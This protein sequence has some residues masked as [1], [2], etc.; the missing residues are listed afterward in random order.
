LRHKAYSS[1]ADLQSNATPFR[2][3]IFNSVQDAAAG[4]PD[5]Y[6]TGKI[7][8]TAKF[9]KYIPSTGGGSGSISNKITISSTVPS[10]EIPAGT[11]VELKASVHG[12]KIYYTIDGTDPQIDE[13]GNLVGSTK[14]YSGEITITDDTTLKGIAVAASGKVK[15]EIG[16]WDYTVKGI[17]ISINPPSG[18]I[19]P[20]TAI[21]INSNKGEKIYYTIDGTDPQ[22]DENG[23]PLGT[24]KEYT[25][26]FLI[27]NET[28]IKAIAVNEDGEISVIASENYS[29]SPELTGEHIAYIQ[30]YPDDE[31][32][33][34]KP[35]TRGEVAEIFARLTVKKINV[36][37]DL[38]TTFTDVPEDSWYHNSIAFMEKS[39]IINGY[40][41]GTFRPDNYITRAE[42]ATM[43]S[44]FDMLPDVNENIFSDVT[45]LHWAFFN[46]NSAYKKGW[47]N[48]YPGDTN[49]YPSHP[50]KRCEA[51]TIVNRMTGRHAEQEFKD[52]DLSGFIIFNDTNTPAS[53]WAFYEVVESSNTHD[54]K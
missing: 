43:A 1:L 39:G 21:T 47:I 24:T 36:E 14:L 27:F 16:K 41:D 25:G 19:R 12:A 20:G 3:Y 53:H 26:E 5:P 46:I 38:K 28:I 9:D 32:K 23:N 11:K 17:D 49:F 6:T 10:G 37:T 54:Y 13:N 40:A 29:L 48:G 51:V 15:S 22:I 30:G 52:A 35:I 34:E 44:R 50:I 33:P 2:S 7:S 31:F 8:A 18:H 4:K 42:F 45:T